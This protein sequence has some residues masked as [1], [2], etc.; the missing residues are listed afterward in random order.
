LAWDYRTAQL[1]ENER[2]L[3]DYAVKLTLTPA[4]TNE[5][6]V[7]T[8]CNHG[9]SDD[10]ITVAVQVIGYFN[11]IN[12]VAEGLGVDMESWMDVPHDQWMRDKGRNYLESVS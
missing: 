8:L 5:H 3:C 4:T 11:Y 12:R 6:D 9:F 2:A 1:S 7:A 10:E